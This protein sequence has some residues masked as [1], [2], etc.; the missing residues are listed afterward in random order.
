MSH[1]ALAPGRVAVITGAAQGIGLAAA[2]RFAGLGMKLCLADNDETAL[3][4]AAEELKGKADLR[5]VGCDVGRLEDVERLKRTAL[6][7]FGEVALLMNNAAV[8]RGGGPF[9]GYDDWRRLF[10]VNLW[11][12][13]HGLQVFTPDLI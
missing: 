6:D 3:G 9:D 7:A 5:A 2:R 13:V 12:V 1:P 10:D 4:R 8:G 11:G